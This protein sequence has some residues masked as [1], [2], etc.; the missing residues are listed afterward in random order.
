VVL[1]S[2]RL[3]VCLSVCQRTKVI[4]ETRLVMWSTSIPAHVCTFVSAESAKLLLALQPM[5]IQTCGMIPSQMASSF[6]TRSKKLYQLWQ[7]SF[8]KHGLILTIFGKQRQ[9]TFKNDMQIQRLSLHF[10]LI[11]LFLNSCNGNDAFWHHSMLVKEFSSLPQETPD[12]LSRSVS[13]KQS[14]WP[15]NPV[16]YRIWRLM[17]ECVYTVQNTC[18]WHQWLDAA[19]QWHIGKHTTKRQSCWSMD[20]AVVCMHE[21]K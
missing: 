12:F 19:H 13:A 15:E 1:F 7:T 21:G 18:P 14:S 8:D 3:S 5:E 4:S 16:D 20:R 9:Q 6:Y 11:Y 10:Y 17:Q 2:T